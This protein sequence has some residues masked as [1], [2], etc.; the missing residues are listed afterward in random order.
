MRISF[1]D[2][3]EII[4]EYKQRINK[5]CDKC[6]SNMKIEM[7]SDKE[8]LRCEWSKCRMTRSFW[9]GTVFENLKHSPEKIVAIIR[10][11]LDRMPTRNICI[12]LQI[13]KKSFSSLF[14][15]LAVYLIPKYYSQFRKIG[16]NNIIVEIDESKFGLR[17]YNRGHRVDG[18]WVL[19]MVERSEAK[20]ILLIT[21]SN[22]TKINLTEKIKTFVNSETSIYT[23][24]WRGYIGLE[25]HFSAHSTVNHSLGF[26]NPSNGVHTNTIEG[27]WSAVK[28]QTPVRCRTRH[29]V[30]LYLVRFMILREERENAFKKLINL[31]F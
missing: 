8:I 23:D 21:V 30:S 3:I 10:L 22:R 2:E 17:K 19:G 25:S 4:Q 29:L 26:V 31:L 5:K 24:E 20:R 28:A 16:G 14:H 7:K 11:W 15:K 12:L 27:N 13:S 18:V 9:K 1:E 6:G